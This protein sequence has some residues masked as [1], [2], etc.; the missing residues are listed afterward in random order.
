M[1]LLDR[2]VD[3]GG[4]VVFTG[5]PADLVAHGG[6]LTARHV[7]TYLKGDSAVS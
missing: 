6:S 5:I 1:A 4:R 2:L 3:D 7:R